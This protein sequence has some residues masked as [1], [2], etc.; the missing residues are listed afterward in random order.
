[1]TQKQKVGCHRPLTAENRSQTNM[2]SVYLIPTQVKPPSCPI[3]CAARAHGFW[4]SAFGRLQRMYIS[5]AG[6][7]L[8]AREREALEVARAEAKE[9]LDRLLDVGGAR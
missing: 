6:R 9:S 4:G 8:G 1:M 2:P 5:L 3:L 7:E